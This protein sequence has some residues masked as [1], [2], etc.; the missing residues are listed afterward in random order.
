MQ[1]KQRN[2]PKINKI[3]EDIP[4]KSTKIG[5]PAPPSTS[6]HHNTSKPIL[7][8]KMCT[9]NLDN[10]NT[11][12]PRPSLTTASTRKGRGTVS[13]PTSPGNRG[14]EKERR[15]KGKCYFIFELPCIWERWK[16]E[17]RHLLSW[18]RFLWFCSVHSGKFQYSMVG[19]NC[20]HIVSSL[21]I[22]NPII[23]CCI[24]WSS[25]SVVTIN[26]K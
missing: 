16:S 25:D 7:E 10:R 14:W 26:Y 11:N 13:E 23:W 9:N 21:L 8:P 6:C 4:E 1:A 19:H 5:Q 20:Y 12:F 18:L 3:P 17:S 15:G 2:V 24:I 22:T